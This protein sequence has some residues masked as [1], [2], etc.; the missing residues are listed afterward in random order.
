[1]EKAKHS[2]E[3]SEME[4]TEVVIQRYYDVVRAHES[5][6]IAGT[7]LDANKVRAMK[8]TLDY[9]NGIIGYN[10]FNTSSQLLNEAIKRKEEASSS[11]E[12]ASQRPNP[13]L[14]LEYIKG[15]EFGLDVN[16]VSVT[17]KH[18]IEFGSKRDKRISKAKSYTKLRN[19]QIEMSLF[20]SNLKAS[21]N[22]QRVAQLNVTIE[23]VKEAIQTFDKITRKLSSRKRLNPEETV[24]LHISVEGTL[25]RTI[26]IALQ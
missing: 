20:G 17:A 26:K 8:S 19:A 6:L 16:S 1:M 9:E 4:V 25:E 3:V 23:S 2:K 7:I 21:I 14:D 24:S 11:L 12:I 15:D 13:E 5:F 10:E 18:V 22:Y